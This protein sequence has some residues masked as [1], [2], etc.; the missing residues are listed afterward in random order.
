MDPIDYADLPEEAKAC[1][2]E[3]QKSYIDEFSFFKRNE[4]VNETI[5]CWY[6][7]EVLAVW[8]GQAWQEPYGSF[9][10]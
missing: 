10:G 2:S 9:E 8:D 7:G 5:V 6:A 3:E 1:I 4:G